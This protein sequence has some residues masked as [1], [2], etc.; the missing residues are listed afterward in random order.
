MTESLRGRDARLYGTDDGVAMS[1]SHDAD[2]TAV[3][4]RSRTD[5][6]LDH[7]TVPLLHHHRTEFTALAGRWLVAPRACPLRED[8]LE[9]LPELSVE[10]AVDYRVEG[11]VTVAE[12]RENLFE[13]KRYITL[14]RLRTW[15]SVDD[16]FLQVGTNLLAW[17]TKHSCIPLERKILSEGDK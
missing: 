14:A 16:K 12:P 8:S 4:A 10:D 9:R 6:T 5:V 11:R 3:R 7:G 17:D 13:R 2:L 1:L 15:T